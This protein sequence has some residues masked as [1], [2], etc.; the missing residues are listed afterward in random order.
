MYIICIYTS[1]VHLPSVPLSCHL[2]LYMHACKYTYTHTRMLDIIV[3]H[4]FSDTAILYELLVKTV[5]KAPV[6][7]RKDLQAHTRRSDYSMDA[8]LK[9]FS[10]DDLMAFSSKVYFN[11]ALGVHKTYKE[12]WCLAF[13]YIFG[14]LVLRTCSTT[15]GVYIHCSKSLFM[16]Y[17]APSRALVFCCDPVFHC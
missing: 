12:G 16:G 8:N 3:C 17:P 7:N 10:S 14:V 15:L 1:N 13:S 5:F 9:N 6:P 4:F 2:I 11:A